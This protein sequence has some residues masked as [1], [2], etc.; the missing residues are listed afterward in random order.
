MCED[1]KSGLNAEFPTFNWLSSDD[2]AEMEIESMVANSALIRA[3]E[4]K[5]I[6][7]PV[8]P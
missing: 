4:G 8:F 1:S 5:N 6:Y 7:S 2:T 3:R